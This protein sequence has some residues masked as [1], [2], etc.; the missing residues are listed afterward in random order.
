VE[1]Y[2]PPLKNYL[3]IDTD[4]NNVIQSLKLVIDYIHESNTCISKK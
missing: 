4:N 2:E 3:D 1:Y